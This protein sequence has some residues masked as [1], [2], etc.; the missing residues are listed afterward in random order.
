MTFDIES[1]KVD[2][3]DATKGSKKSSTTKKRDLAET[4][5]RKKR[6]AEKL[7]NE[8]MKELRELVDDQI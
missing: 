8:L 7:T 5:K 3:G 2:Q 1:D 4:K 6:K